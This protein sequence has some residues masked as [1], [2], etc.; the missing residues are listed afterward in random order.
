MAH[1]R[2]LPWHD[3]VVRLTQK[4]HGTVGPYSILIPARLTTSAHL[5]ISAFTNGSMSLSG[6]LDGSPAVAAMRCWMVGSASAFFTSACSFSMIAG[7]V[8]LGAH[9][10]NQVAYSYP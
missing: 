3:A 10:P 9:M 1:M 6:M 5:T 2:P 4:P 8:C 7:G